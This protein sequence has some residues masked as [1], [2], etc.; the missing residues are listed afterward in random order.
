[1]MYFLIA[2]LVIPMLLLRRPQ[3]PLLTS[4]TK[5]ILGSGWKNYGPSK[6]G[7]HHNGTSGVVF[8]S[9]LCLVKS[10]V[11]VAL[12]FVALHGM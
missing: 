8:M 4:T 7:F 9:P 1:M 12:F 3:I 6:D 2:Q 11:G 10:G 5:I